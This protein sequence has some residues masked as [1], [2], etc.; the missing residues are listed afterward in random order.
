MCC[1]LFQVDF[2]MEIVYL[3]T[4]PFQICIVAN[5]FYADITIQN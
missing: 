5:K 1:L 3:N 4:T 2:I